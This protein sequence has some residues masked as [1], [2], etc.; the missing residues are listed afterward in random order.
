MP[1]TPATSRESYHAL[2]ASGRTTHDRGLVLAALREILAAFPDATRGEVEH[3][4]VG[5]EGPAGRH[6]AKRVSEIL[7]SPD[8]PL[9]EGPVRPCR[10]TGRRAGTVRWRGAV[11]VEVAPPAPVPTPRVYD[12]CG[13]ASSSTTVTGTATR[14]DPEQQAEWEDAEAERLAAEG[15][16]ASELTEYESL[17]PRDYVSTSERVPWLVPPLE[18]V[19]TLSGVV[20]VRRGLDVSLGGAASVGAE[21]TH[22]TEAGRLIA[23]G[24]I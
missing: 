20:T 3:H 6:K 19:G 5:R 4:F 11:P 10:A 18:G 23:A 22:T 9:E 12:L 24:V 21:L 14:L 15:G 8:S 7:A 13:T 16:G 1:T 2:Q 17:D